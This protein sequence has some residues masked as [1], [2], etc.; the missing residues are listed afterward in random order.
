MTAT[1]VRGRPTP[2]APRDYRFPRFERRVLS[3]GLRLIVSTVNKLPVVTVVAVVDA[4]AVC[5][6]AGCE[7]LAELV[8]KLLLEGTTT[9]D[10]AELIA[11]FESLGASVDASADWDSAAVTMTALTENLA[12]AFEILAEVLRMPAFREREVERLKA[13]RLAELLQLRTE[14]RGLADEL[15][16]RFL[17][18]PTSR[19]ARP[20]GGDEESVKAIGRN[21]VRS[22]FESRYVPSATTL[23]IVGDITPRAAEDLV[24]ATL[25]AWSGASPR[26]IMA[27]DQPARHESSVHIVTKP[28]A[29]QS[30]LRIGQVGIPRK[31]PDY[32][33][34][35]VMNAVLGGLFNSRINLNL[36]E[37][38]GY[39]YGA[40]SGFE[41]R[42]Q[43][44]PFAVST[45]VKSEVT[46]AAARE[47]LLEIDRMRTTPI[48]E[49][50][51]SL[52]TS[53]LDGVFPI[54]YETTAAIAAALANLMVYELP[55]DYFDRYREHVRAVTREQVLDAAQ[56]HLTPGIFQM[57]VVGDPATVRAP[58]E[59]LGFGPVRLYDAQGRLAE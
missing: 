5:D 39:T 19:Y 52:A 38:H 1:R 20:D 32:F 2:S 35:V 13:E 44:G 8:A 43:A 3:N 51:L 27:S 50:E 29:P 33:P 59:G 42:R 57:V 45:A 7:G 21:D 22:F 30:E 10:G 46:D 40:F 17:Y 54:R 26:R 31:H 9:S 12:P 34:T 24:V 55:D 4:G 11:R 18:E 49:D 41:W 58:L 28:D 15:F 14:P 53:Y 47:V 25:G 16:A 48:A 23:V 6:P 37:A 56:K 36:R